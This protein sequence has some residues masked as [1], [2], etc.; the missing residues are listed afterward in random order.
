MTNTQCVDCGVSIEGKEGY[1]YCPEC[2]EETYYSEG[3]SIEGKEGY[4][5]CPE[6]DT[7]T[8]YSEDDVS[9]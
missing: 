9:G 6:C 3:S 7:E 4:R 1:R 5:Y 2:D 8:Y